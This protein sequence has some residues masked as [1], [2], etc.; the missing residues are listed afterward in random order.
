MLINVA[1]REWEKDILTVM[2]ECEKKG[3]DGVNQLIRGL[4]RK[5]ERQSKF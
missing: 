1:K 2:R 4:K 3:L 5:N